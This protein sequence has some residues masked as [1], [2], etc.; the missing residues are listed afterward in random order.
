MKKLAVITAVTVLAFTAQ[1]LM[2]H[3]Y[4]SRRIGA[5]ISTEEQETLRDA[6]N[7]DTAAIPDRRPAG[8]WER[9]DMKTMSAGEETALTLPAQGEG[10]L[11]WFPSSRDSAMFTITGYQH[12]RGTDHYTIR[13]LK[14]GKTGLWFKLIPQSDENDIHDIKCFALNIN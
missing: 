13:G 7:S 10:G 2:I 6:L 8:P 5:R 14:K 12:G 3:T 1:M 11:W 9:C 4:K